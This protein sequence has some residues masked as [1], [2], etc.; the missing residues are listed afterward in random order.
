VFRIPLTS[1]FGKQVLESPEL[2]RNGTPVAELL[3]DLSSSN[4]AAA[5]DGVQ[6]LPLN[7]LRDA[8]QRGVPMSLSSVSAGHASQPVSP[9]VPARHSRHILSRQL[10]VRS[11]V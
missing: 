9:N 6:V 5:M 3:N 7:I 8:S 4:S 11:C 10:T 1:S 2:T